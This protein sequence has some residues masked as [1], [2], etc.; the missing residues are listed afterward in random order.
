MLKTENITQLQTELAKTTAT[1]EEHGDDLDSMDADIEAL[2]RRN[3]KLEAYTRR[4]N[5]RIYS[6]NE[7]S[8]ENI[9]DVVRHLFLSKMQI[10]PE[11]VKAIKTSSQRSQSRPRP[12]IARFSHYQ[13]KEFVRSFYKKLKG[14]DIG[15]SDDFPKEIEDIHKTLY[16][17]LKKAKR[18]QKKAFFNFDKLII[19]G[20]LYRGKETKNLP[21]YGNIMKTFVYM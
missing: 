20:Q 2:K 4:E 15:I 7:E 14:T 9:E 19:E 21:S 3:I 8:E 18:D 13:D 17:V 10:P 6:V 12:V 1:V 5:M 16:P 11:A